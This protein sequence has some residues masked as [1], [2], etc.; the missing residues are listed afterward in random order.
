MQ[1]IIP[2]I[3]LVH[4][5]YDFLYKVPDVPPQFMHAGTRISESIEY[6]MITYHVYIVPLLF[7]I[8]LA[9]FS[10]EL[11]KEPNKVSSTDG[12]YVN[13]NRTI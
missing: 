9:H 4:Y 5:M 1:I 11:K 3:R 6:R 7:I 10:A 13:N 12:C 2:F 8:A